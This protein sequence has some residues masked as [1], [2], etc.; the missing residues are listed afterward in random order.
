[1]QICGFDYVA[2]DTNGDGTIDY[3][4]LMQH[5]FG[6]DKT[7]LQEAVD[8]NVRN[9]K[10]RAN[11]LHA[12]SQ[13]AA[14]FVGSFVRR[15]NCHVRC[16]RLG[17]VQIREKAIVQFVNQAGTMS[18]PATLFKAL[19]DRINPDE[20]GVRRAFQHFRKM[21]SEASKGGH[22]TLDGFRGA[23]RSFQLSVS[24]HYRH[25]TEVPMRPT[26]TV[27]IWV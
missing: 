23:L 14:C 18:S 3:Q 6:I 16:F 1:M 27:H 20:N 22:I 13:F 15:A 5:L 25:E 24:P 9:A 7:G 11:T 21:S 4:E 8:W 17:C 19:R 10:A 12:H 26:H 2:T